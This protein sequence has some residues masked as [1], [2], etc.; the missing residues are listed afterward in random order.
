[1]ASDEIISVK[2]NKSIKLNTVIDSE[3]KEL[4]VAPRR[5]EDEDLILQQIYDILSVTGFLKS[6]Y[7]DVTPFEKIIRGTIACLRTFSSYQNVDLPI[8]FEEELHIKEKVKMSEFIIKFLISNEIKCPIILQPHQIMG[9]DVEKILP[10]I[11]W[12]AKNFAKYRKPAAESHKIIGNTYFDMHFNSVLNIE[13]KELES[14]GGLM[15]FR[16]ILKVLNAYTP[17]RAYKYA[18]SDIKNS[19]N[20]HDLINIVYY[21][22]DPNAWRK[23]RNKT[24]KEK[25]CPIKNY[26]ICNNIDRAYKKEKYDLLQSDLEKWSAKASDDYINNFD[27]TTLKNEE[28][29][30]IISIEDLENEILKI[31]NEISEAKN[32]IQEASSHTNDE[33]TFDKFQKII[34][35]TKKTR[36]EYSKLCALNSELDSNQFNDETSKA[37]IN[38]LTEQIKQC[39]NL[40]ERLE[41]KID[42]IKLKIAH[43]SK[44]IYQLESELDEPGNAELAM[45]YLRFQELYDEVDELTNQTRNYY[46][47]YNTLIDLKEFKNKEINLWNSVLENYQRAMSS[48][49]YREQ[50]SNHLESVI[51]WT[52]QTE[53]KLDKTFIKKKQ[54]KSDLS[55]ELENLLKLEEVYKNIVKKLTEK[56]VPVAGKMSYNKYKKWMVDLDVNNDS[57]ETEH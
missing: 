52:T 24:I 12:L 56:S 28:N 13:A 9:L 8:G 54:E 50:F 32:V 37:K 42:K 53:Q 45:Y 5:H 57:N 19:L 44:K 23:S 31:D 43:E 25:L 33:E 4:E 11:K 39:T 51:E 2:N 15:L 38:A 29:E 30:L 3:G 34:N 26:K 14:S 20:D 18:N 10:L 22:S 36:E 16:S 21:G 46:D 7:R 17:A 40:Q 1:M 35:E 27:I 6:K 55:R 47:A 49:H 48:A 41:K